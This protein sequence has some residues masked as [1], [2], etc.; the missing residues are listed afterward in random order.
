MD[1]GA[2]NKFIARQFVHKYFLTISELPEKIPLVILDSS[3][4][5]PLFVTHHNKYIVEPPSFQSFEWDFLVIDIPKGEDLILGFD[6]LDNFD[7]SIDWRQ[8]L[9]PF[10]ANNKDYYYPSNS[11][12]NNFSS[13]ESC[14]ALDGDSRTPSFPSSFH[15]PFFKSHTSLLSSRD[16][17]FK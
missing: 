9:I 11:F 14:A 12:I 6:F 13:A 8:R 3:E 4:S 2:T 7:P 16:E 17:V 1:Y 15:I 10:D 5:P